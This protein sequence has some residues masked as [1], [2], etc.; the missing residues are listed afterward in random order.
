MSKHGFD[1]MAGLSQSF[2]SRAWLLSV[3]ARGHSMPDFCYGVESTIG[4]QDWNSRVVSK[5]PAILVASHLQVGL[6]NV[7]AMQQFATGIATARQLV[8]FCKLL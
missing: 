8:V 6:R 2:A 1:Q 5:C 3:C 4:A 7:T